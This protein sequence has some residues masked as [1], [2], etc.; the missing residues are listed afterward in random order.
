MR[1]RSGSKSACSSSRTRSSN[2][3]SAWTK[4][5][6]GSG[7]S[8]SAT[9]FSPASMNATTSSAREGAGAIS[10]STYGM[11]TL[12][13]V[14]LRASA[15]C[16]I[17]PTPPRA[18]RTALSGH[19]QLQFQQVSPM[20]PVYSVTDL[21]GCSNL[22]VRARPECFAVRIPEWDEGLH[23]LLSELLQPRL[24]CAFP[25]HRRGS[26]A[27]RGRGRVPQLVTADGERPLLLSPAPIGERG[28][29]DLEGKGLVRRADGEGA[30]V[31][32]APP[33]DRLVF[34]R[35]GCC[36]VVGGDLG[37][38]GTREGDHIATVGI[39][40][41]DAFRIWTE[42]VGL[43]PALLGYGGDERPGSDEVL[44]GLSEG[45]ASGQDHSQKQQSHSAQS[46][47]AHR[48]HGSS[49]FVWGV[50]E[51]ETLSCH[52]RC[53]R[54]TSVHSGETLPTP[55]SGAAGA[56]RPSAIRLAQCARRRLHS[57]GIGLGPL[58]VLLG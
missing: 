39:H 48:L 22:H 29:L 35:S 31:G 49:P 56:R 23:R 27:R 47:L 24:P 38:I 20:L 19:H 50:E 44:G 54:H 53:C 55:G 37:K 5:M 51:I 34:L 12:R 6:M 15:R 52:H 16:V 11:A 26:A 4:S 32:E 42:R 41:Q 17:P 43:V 14:A 57:E 36:A 33:D 9:S 3:S 10:G 8:I 25:D 45:V 13:I 46:E 58:G 28:G 40:Y 2:R 7:P 21:P 1:E 18:G 30:E